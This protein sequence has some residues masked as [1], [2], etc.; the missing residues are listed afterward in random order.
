MAAISWL[1]LLPLGAAM[2][3]GPGTASPA[4]V[5]LGSL[6]VDALDVWGPRHRLHGAKLVGHSPGRAGDGAGGLDD[7]ARFP[8]SGCFDYLGTESHTASQFLI[9]TGPQRTHLGRS[10][11]GR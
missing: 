7:R 5:R 2:S 8:S 4:G 10:G 3:A 6:L 11:N 9:A 1:L